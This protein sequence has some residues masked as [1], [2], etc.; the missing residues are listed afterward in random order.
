MT[1]LVQQSKL[2]VEDIDRFELPKATERF[3]GKSAT[4]KTP[5]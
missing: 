1:V 3:F 4:D 5:C 2:G